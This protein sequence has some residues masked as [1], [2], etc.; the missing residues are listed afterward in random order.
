[1]TPL[2]GTVLVNGG[3]GRW[4]EDSRGAYKRL[5]EDR[6]VGDSPQMR[7]IEEQDVVARCWV[8]STW[9]VGEEASAP[10][11]P[12]SRCSFNLRFEVVLQ[13]SGASPP[14]SRTWRTRPLQLT[15]MLEPNVILITSSSSSMT[16][17]Y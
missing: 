10:P 14:A 12:V 8:D 15:G 9:S 17:L 5:R 6:D 7:C 13:P 1:M 2:S 16:I 11:T 4:S 3:T